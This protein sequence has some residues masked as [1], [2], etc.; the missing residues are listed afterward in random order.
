MVQIFPTEAQM[1]KLQ[2]IQK[3]GLLH[4][5][6]NSH[7]KEP[8]IVVTAVKRS[9]TERDKMKLLQAVR[10]RRRVVIKKMTTELPNRATTPIAPNIIQNHKS[11]EAWFGPLSL[12]V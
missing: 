12:N 9:D 5:T 2:K 3:T 8:G 11:I 7:M 10:S 1:K 6:P 4:C